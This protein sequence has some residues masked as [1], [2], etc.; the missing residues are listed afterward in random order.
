MATVH[1][2]IVMSNF[3]VM[4]Q[5][6]SQG[7]IF[8]PQNSDPSKTCFSEKLPKH[9]LWK[10]PI[11][12]PFPNINVVGIFSQEPCYRVILSQ[13]CLLYVRALHVTDWVRTRS[14][15]WSPRVTTA[16]AQEPRFLFDTPPIG[17]QRRQSVYP[18]SC[19]RTPATWL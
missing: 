1:H 10:R 8:Q 6:C 3:H 15:L 5:I 17:L 9:I 18:R 2:D 4:P 7:G 13:A 14:T 12:P 19:D 16:L 11:L